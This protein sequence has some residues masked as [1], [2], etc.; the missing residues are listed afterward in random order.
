VHWSSSSSSGGPGAQIRRSC[1]WGSRGAVSLRPAPARLCVRLHLLLVGVRPPDVLQ[2][3]ARRA[4]GPALSPGPPPH[5]LTPCPPDPCHSRPDQP[6]VGAHQR[7]GRPPVPRAEPAPG[8]RLHP[9]VRGAGAGAGGGGAREAGRAHHRGECPHLLPCSGGPGLGWAGLGW[10]ALGWAGLG[11]AGLGWGWAG[12]SGSLLLL[13]RGRGWRR[14]LLAP[15]G[16]THCSW[17]AAGLSSPLL[18][19]GPARPPTPNPPTPSP[20]P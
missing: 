20:L 3:G 16:G 5:G 14:G 11:W 10:A 17:P 8:R 2:A 9:R 18:A 19:A 13:A 6:P 4:L 7:G 15:A 1:V 12:A